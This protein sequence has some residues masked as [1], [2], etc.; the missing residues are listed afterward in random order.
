MLPAA[1]GFLFNQTVMRF[2][3]A[4]Y[5]QY[6]SKKKENKGKDEKAALDGGEQKK[7]EQHVA[8]FSTILEQG[9]SN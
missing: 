2:L 3:K 4:I 8:V 9:V 5:A 7:E 1:L 6:F